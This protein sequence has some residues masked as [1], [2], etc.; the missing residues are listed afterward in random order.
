[1]TT[2]MLVSLLL[3]SCVGTDEPRTA[4]REECAELRRIEARLTVA[5]GSPAKKTPEVAAQLSRHEKSLS[6]LGGDEAIARCMKEVKPALIEC[7]RSARTLP[8]LDRCRRQ[9]A[10]E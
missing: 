10:P 7:S 1:M 9:G 3:S 6:S 8:D 2:C 5:A 4:T